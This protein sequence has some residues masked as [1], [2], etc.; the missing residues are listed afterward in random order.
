MTASSIY[1]DGDKCTSAD[2]YM[3]CQLGDNVS[4]MVCP[5]GLCYATSVALP[6]G[7]C[8]S[9]ECVSSVL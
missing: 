9:I 6:V 7:A 4:V 8:Q 1:N 2:G 5:S 3:A